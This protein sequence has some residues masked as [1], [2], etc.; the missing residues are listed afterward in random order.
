ML[1]LELQTGDLLSRHGAERV[2]LPVG[3][4]AGHHG[5]ARLGGT[6]G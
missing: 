4:R 2:V 1:R 5:S 3:V 6:G